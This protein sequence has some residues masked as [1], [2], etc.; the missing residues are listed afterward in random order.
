MRLYE[1]SVVK[2]VSA[3]ER[4]AIS[5]ISM[6]LFYNRF[7]G[8]FWAGLFYGLGLLVFLLSLLSEK[9]W[10]YRSMMI[11]TVFGF[12]A[13]L[14]ALALR[15]IIMSRPPVSNLFETFVFVGAFCV[16]MGLIM[17]KV[18]KSWIGLIV[19]DVCGV[20]M[21]AIAS[22]FANDGD[23]MQMLIAVLNSNFW[24]ST[25]VIAITV[26][27]AGCCVAGIM[28]HI[29]VLQAL[30]Q[31]GNQKRLDNTYQN[32]LGVL[33]FGLTMSFLGTALGG[34]W[35]D[36]SWGRFWGWDP[37]EN[38]ALMIVLWSAIVFHAKIAK[39]INPLGVAVGCILAL[40][41]VMWAWFGVNLLSIGLH[42]YGFASGVAG[43]LIAYVIAEVVFISVSVIVLGRKNIKF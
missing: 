17:E 8:L 43:G 32:M 26:G 3:K 31:P 5:L 13:H 37:K 1:E 2:R 22:K 29:Y 11:L 21:L 19:A 27:Y 15:V 16:F 34:V 36:Q 40:V 38:G 18:N 4:K 7:N 25:H 30:S 28:G 6:E 12:A 35:A 20:I 24:L 14:A 23:T 42:S 33:G 10:M 39:V 41:V 9:P